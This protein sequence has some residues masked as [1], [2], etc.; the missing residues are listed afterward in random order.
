MKKSLIALAALAA[1][2]AVSAQSS[3][4]MYGRIDMGWGV[5]TTK[6]ANG[7]QDKT[8]GLVDG[9]QTSNAIGF[10]G[11]E[12]LGGGLVA[13]FNLEQGISPT[14][15][16]GWNQRLGSSGH[17]VGGG[18]AI[19]AATMRAGNVSLT[20]KDMGA[21]TLGT[22]QWSAGYTVASRWGFF[23]EGFGGGEA[24]TTMPAR[25]TGASYTTPAMGGVTVTVQHGGAHGARTERESA[26]DAADGF[27]KNKEVRTGINA[28][29]NAGP[30]YLG[31]AYESTA[32]NKVANAA[33]TTNAYGGA[34]K[35]GTAGVRTENAWTVAANYDFGVAVV[36]G[37]I[38][39][40]D[41]GAATA[42]KTSG[43]GL[44]VA[45]PVGALTL[46]AA[47]GMTEVKT[48]ATTTSDISGH[49]LTAR[50]NLSK[51]TNVYMHYGTDKDSKAASTAQ[52]KR[53]RTIAGVVHTF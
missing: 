11:T 26:A 1:V 47:T 2:G 38:V 23:A 35:P 4:T 6:A 34:V 33:D 43:R 18:G 16:N 14:Q 29:Y 41:N 5:A 50:Y 12:D 39:E 30:L 37:M 48:G 49:Q 3:V 9:V 20:T 40:R 19:T 52:G 32:I 53:T 44:S 42:V 51:R 13:G 22:I 24:H 10:R 28:Q 8:T 25:I 15:S 31:A 27:R 17:Q 36:R 21:L 7:T 46:I 45:V